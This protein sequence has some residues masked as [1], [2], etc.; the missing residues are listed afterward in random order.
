[1]GDRPLI[2]GAE[3]DCQGPTEPDGG[4]G[5]VGCGVFV[6]DRSV[7]GGGRDELIED[8]ACGVAL[9]GPVVVVEKRVNDV[10]GAESTVDGSVQVPPQ[11]LASARRRCEG[12]TTLPDRTVQDLDGHGSQQLLLIGEVSVQ[13]GDPHTGT[14][15]HGV[16]GGFATDVEDQLDRRVDDRLPV[17]SSVSAHR[18]D[19]E[20]VVRRRSQNGV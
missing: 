4:Q 16:S 12:G 18:A 20:A 11:R 13:G 15:S 3:A 7:T 9:V 17:P 19:Q 1:M 6:V 2:V 8:V 10:D 5:D 14:L